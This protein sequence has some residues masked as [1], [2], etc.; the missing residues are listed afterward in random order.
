MPRL[1]AEGK[2]GENASGGTDFLNAD[3]FPYSVGRTVEYDL[4]V[5]IVGY[6]VSTMRPECAYPVLTIVSDRYFFMEC[7]KPALP[8]PASA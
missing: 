3:E 8:E 1:S 6:V 4:A 2:I 7:F 5:A